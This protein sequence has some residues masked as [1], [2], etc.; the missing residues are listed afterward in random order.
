[1]KLIQLTILL[2]SLITLKPLFAAS[3]FSKNQ[4][5]ETAE[6][7]MEKG[8]TNL[9]Y[10]IFSKLTKD[11]TTSKTLQY[12][13]LKD[14]ARVHLI[15]QDF[16]NYDRIN[17]KAN[18]LYKGRGDIYEALYFAERA[19]FWH[20]LT[21]GDS[22]VYYSD[23]S[24]EIATR[25]RREFSKISAAFIYQIYA[26]TCLY[27]HVD[28]D[29]KV[30]DG[31]NL[32]GQ[33]AK[34]FQ[35]FDSALYY[36]DR[37]PFRF[38]SE[39]GLLYRS[40]G[41]R[42][43]DML[44]YVSRTKKDQKLLTPLNRISYYNAMKYYTLSNKN[45]D[46]ENCNDR[47]INE[48]LIGMTF[49]CFGE[50]IKA[51]HTYEKA[52][53]EFQR[54]NGDLSKTTVPRVL[55]DMYS[56]KLQN[57][58]NL[59]FNLKK[60]DKDIY[61]LE[62]LRVSWW[63]TLLREGKH[64][65]D[66]FAISPYY[67]LSNL[68]LRKFIEYNDYNAL[69]KA[70][71]LILTEKNHFHFLEKT[72]NQFNLRIKNAAIEFNLIK[73]TTFKHYLED[74]LNLNSKKLELINPPYITIKSI[75]KKLKKDDYFLISYPRYG[76]FGKNKLL[77]GK[78]SVA[79]I[80]CKDNTDGFRNVSLADYDFKSFKKESYS[81]YKLYFEE[82]FKLKPTIKKVYVSYDD[83]T[84]Y[85]I[86]IKDTVGNNFDQLNYLVKS[87]QFVTI[88]NPYV[89]FLDSKPST[90]KRLD[91]L[92]IKLRGTSDLLFTEKLASSKFQNYQKTEANLDENWER[93]LAKPGVLH[94]YG[95]GSVARDS[96][97]ASKYFSLDFSSKDR[98]K[99]VNRINAKTN[100]N[101]S[102]V[103]LNNCFSGFTIANKNEYDRGIYLKLLNGGVNHVIISPNETDDE[104]SSILFSSFYKNIENGFSVNDAFYSAQ[105][106]YL[107]TAKGAMAHP[108]YWSSFQVISNNSTPIYK[109]NSVSFELVLFFGF[110]I[111]LLF[112]FV[113]I[114]NK[115]KA[116]P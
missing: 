51:M 58:Y 103:V 41:N 20:T 2:A 64:T 97:S 36:S 65:Y 86:L 110:S 61:I 67:Q 42:H 76:F 70:T 17:T 60:T 72:F 100:F 55:L 85:S 71:S 5:I 89:F 78:D 107:E 91:F 111:L 52:I 6:S 104:V 77:I 46:P 53:Y 115:L 27:R 93:Y 92:K 63:E 82:I 11:K 19:Y 25:N 80:K 1:M 112:L 98:E 45:L 3:E 50:K 74:Y 68:Y 31:M 23:K 105:K 83:Y 48:S 79:V 113:F 116:R 90:S 16:V 109:A 38:I 33:R 57:D 114:F 32:K 84:R 43:L 10:L 12:R 8:K 26:I 88:Y 30:N 40:I 35:Y 73:N 66:I 22:A 21:W 44:G 59:P 24:I 34:M 49:A 18:K 69:E 47:L 94:I 56:F 54:I 7:L 13:L 108:V 95:H 28:E 99:S 37:Y 106:S 81:N 62:K 75:Q 87:I 4:L 96:A 29:Y 39:K 101:K 15:E 9:A 102:L 14:I